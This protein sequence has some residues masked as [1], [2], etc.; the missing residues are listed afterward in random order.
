MT[1]IPQDPVNSEY[2][3]DGYYGRRRRSLDSF[4][5]H[6]EACQLTCKAFHNVASTRFRMGHFEEANNFFQQE[7]CLLLQIIPL[8]E[9]K[10]TRFSTAATENIT[11]IDCSLMLKTT[12]SPSFSSS[13]GS[14][15]RILFILEELIERRVQ[16]SRSI[17][18][19]YFARLDYEEAIKQYLSFLASSKSLVE[20]EQVYCLLG[21]CYQLVNN[22]AQALV[23]CEKRLVLAHEIG[24]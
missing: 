3:S 14:V 23:S 9:K 10:V 24:K 19:C 18:D 11:Q 16:C 13:S 4:L 7:L 21:K 22:L 6:V 5:D 15:N 20:Q 1:T 2:D 12:N 8:A 17:G